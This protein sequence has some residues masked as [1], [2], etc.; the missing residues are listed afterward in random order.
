MR[1]KAAP[2]TH[3]H[4]KSVMSFP[5]SSHRNQD[6]IGSEPE[7]AVEFSGTIAQDTVD[8]MKRT[9]HPSFMVNSI[10]K[11][12]ATL[13]ND[14]Q[15]RRTHQ[16]MFSKHFENTSREEVIYDGARHHTVSSHMV[17][18]ESDKKGKDGL[19]LSSRGTRM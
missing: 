13:L 4:I 17:S 3:A 11:T 12:E 6:S 7:L 10:L 16:H 1:A 9:S 19:T 8:E 2:K 14:S 5:S 18:V 15:Q